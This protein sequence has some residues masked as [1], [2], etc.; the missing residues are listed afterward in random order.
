MQ[1]FSVDIDTLVICSAT[2]FIILITGMYNV[3]SPDGMV[4]LNNIGET[5]AGSSNAQ[6]AIETVEK[7]I[8]L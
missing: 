2:A 6:L 3:E 8:S 5:E 4:I 1:A 7:T